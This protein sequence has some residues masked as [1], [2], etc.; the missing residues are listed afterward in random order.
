MGRRLV[1]GAL[2][3]LAVAGPA[4]AAPGLI[5]GVDDDT[6]KWQAQPAT[7]LAIMRD[8]GVKAVRV[9]VSWQAGE[10]RISPW[11]QQVLD[12]VIGA[13]WGL[14]VV[15]AVYGEPG[16]APLDAPVRTA[17]CDAVS[18]L[19]RRYPTVNDVVIW[20]EP[21]TSAF[22]RP[23]F[24]ADGSSAAPAAYEA[25]L[26][27]CWDELHGVRPGV[28]VIAAS[29]PRGKDNPA[30]LDASHSPGSWYRQLGAAYRTS[31]RTRR[32]FDTVGHNPYPDNSAERPWTQHRSVSTGEGDYGKLMAALQDGFGGTGQPLPGHGGV[33][34]WYM[35]QGFQSVVA[36]AKLPFYSGRETDRFAL[37]AAGGG[38]ALDQATQITDAVQLAS[39]Q[40][41]VGAIFNF[42]LADEPSLGGWQ[43]GVLWADSTRKP[44][45]DAFKQAIAATAVGNV[46]CSRFP[47]TS[48]TVTDPGDIRFTPPPRHQK[49]KP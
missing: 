48:R 18:D 24:A 27:R 35:E 17:Y 31:K 12:R 9:T 32:I 38:T 22:W 33:S 30:A 26:A 5:V 49:Q 44:S 40:P 46:D 7:T 10:S 21:N 28:N 42:E 19:L 43:S 3:A 4:R 1:C 14:R 23:Q 36:P 34:I 29:S 6:L 15:V 16:D 20:N 11:N 39:C 41:G 13:A 37:S 2:L 25:L 45:Y 8:L 47:L